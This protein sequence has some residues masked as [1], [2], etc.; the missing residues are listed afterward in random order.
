MCN[1]LLISLQ[2]F[3]VETTASPSGSPPSFWV[4]PRL[5]TRW[6]TLPNGGCC[7]PGVKISTILLGVASVIH[8]AAY[9]AN[10]GCCPPGV[11]ISTPSSWAWPRLF[12]RWPT[13]PNGGCPPAAKI[14]SCLSCYLIKQRLRSVEPL[15]SFLHPLFTYLGK[16]RP[17]YLLASPGDLLEQTEAATSRGL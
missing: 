16:E 6:P 8:T 1:V 17:H 11:K 9:I 10:G 13:L 3:Q 7:P 14:S 12:T 2:C 4:W 5:F 15:R